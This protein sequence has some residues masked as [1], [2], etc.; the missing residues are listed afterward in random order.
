M[1]IT[2]L[3]GWGSAPD[4]AGELIA[5]PRPLNAFKGQGKGKREKGREGEEMAGKQREGKGMG[6][7]P[8]SP[9]YP[10]DVGVLE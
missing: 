5:L 10:P 4:P 8:A 2:E 6:S 1:R 7:S 3:L 9:D